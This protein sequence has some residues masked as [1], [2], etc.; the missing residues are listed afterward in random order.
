[1]K[2]DDFQEV[3]EHRCIPLWTMRWLNVR[4]QRQARNEGYQL[5]RG[6]QPDEGKA[7]SATDLSPSASK[8]LLGCTIHLK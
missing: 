7:K 8:V 2:T 4:H 6:E 1:M 3:E 5:K